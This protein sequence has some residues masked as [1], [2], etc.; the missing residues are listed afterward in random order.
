MLIFAHR[1][2]SGSAP[3]NTLLAIQ[4]A[5]DEQADAIEIDLHEVDGKIVIIH[6]RWLHLT[7]SGT[8]LIHQKTFD[9]IRSLNAGRGEHIPTLDEIF[10]LVAGKCQINLELKGIEDIN[11]LFRYIDDAIKKGLIK[12]T[13]LILS[14]FNHQLLHHIYQQRPEFSIGAL[15]AA[16]PLQY[17]EFASELNAYSIHINVNFI[18]QAFV[19]DAHSRGLKVYVYTV[20]EQEDIDMVQAM[21][22]DGIFCNYPAKAK[23]YLAKK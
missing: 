15:A 9:Y 20:D 2:A 12:N 23:A 5:L 1:G 6:D 13:D 14:S 18:S 17:A 3:E 16:I 11:L 8:G 22:V 4:V 10:T 7:T 21:N 19:Q